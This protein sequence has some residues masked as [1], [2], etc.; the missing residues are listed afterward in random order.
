[1]KSPNKPEKDIAIIST[2]T[3]WEIDKIRIPSED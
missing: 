1:M 2:C 3:S